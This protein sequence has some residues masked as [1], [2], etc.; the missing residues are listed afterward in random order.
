MTDEERI[1][2]A[3]DADLRENTAIG[4]KIASEMTLLDAYITRLS[5]EDDIIIM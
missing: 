3:V 2:I 1:A 5:C 4:R